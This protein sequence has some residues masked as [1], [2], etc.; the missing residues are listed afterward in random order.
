M[1]SAL[2]VEPKMDVRGEIILDSLPGKIRRRWR[3][4]RPED[5]VKPAQQ[6]NDDDRRPDP[7]TSVF[8]Y[9]TYAYASLA[10]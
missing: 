5:E 8:H 2:E 7:Q 4:T 1:R 3:M 9:L 6:Y 10:A